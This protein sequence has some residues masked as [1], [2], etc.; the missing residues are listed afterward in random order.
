MD[1]STKFPL[2]IQSSTIHIEFWTLASFHQGIE[3]SGS[4][5]QFSRAGASNTWQTGMSSDNSYVTRAPDAT[6]M[7]IVNQNGDATISGSLEVQR[8]SITNTTARP[9]AINNTMHDGPYLVAISQNDSNNDLSFALRCLPLNQL[10]CFGVATSNQYIT[11][12]GNPTKS[13]IQSNGNTTI[14]GNLDV[15]PSQ[16]QSNVKTYCNYVGSF[17]FMMIEGRYRDQGFLHF[18]TNYQYG[19]MLLTAR[20]TYFIRCSD[21]AGNPYAQTFQ[22]LTQSSD[23]R[24]K[25]NEELIENA[26]ETFFKLRPQLYDKKR[27][28]K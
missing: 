11:S 14:S 3:N 17:G 23:D 2:D 4:W 18:E 22:P 12:H 6:N 15:G 21:Y 20:D 8:L 9:I 24:L 25:E 7:L 26:C 28:G 10:W 13:S 1:S 27:Y 5:R 16:A 19:E